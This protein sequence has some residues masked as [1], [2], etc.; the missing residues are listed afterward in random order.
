MARNIMPSSL[1]MSNIMVVQDTGIGMSAEFQKTMFEPFT[2][3]HRAEA[4]N[5]A[6]T[7]LGL[8][9]VKKIVTLM[10]GTISVESTEGKG[11]KITV[12]LPLQSVKTE[13]K[14]RTVSQQTA[15][16]AGR[17]ILLCEDNSLNTEIAV[18][19]LKENGMSVECA[20]NGKEG[21]EKFASSAQ[22]YF[23]AILM[24][25]RMPVMDGHEATKTIRK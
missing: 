14:K 20:A 2:Q 1:T 19:L 5:I 23:D 9:I 10:N 24:D 21:V 18:I 6:G 8:T 13:E 12:N 16:L 25:I 22:G 11:T 4:R 7:G 15:N 3:E 17:K